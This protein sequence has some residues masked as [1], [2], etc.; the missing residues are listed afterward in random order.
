[1][2]EKEIQSYI[3]YVRNILYILDNQIFKA[4]CIIR[5]KEGH[6]LITKTSVYQEDLK[7]L[8]LNGPN[9]TDSKDMKENLIDL[10]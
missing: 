7:V 1:M 3:T 4:K 9:N 5:D 8:K 10:Y 6:L 2:T